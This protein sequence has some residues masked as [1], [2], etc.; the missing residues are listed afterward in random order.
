VIGLNQRQA[1]RHGERATSHLAI[2]PPRWAMLPTEIAIP[3]PVPLREN[4]GCIRLNPQ[5]SCCCRDGGRDFYNSERPTVVHKCTVYTLTQAFVAD[6]ELQ[7]CSR[8]PR[9]SRRYIGPEPRDI[10]LFNYNNRA[11][12]SHEVLNEYISAFSSSVTPFEAWVDHMNRRYQETTP[13]IPF[14]RGALFRSAWFAYGRL[15][16]LDG[17]KSCPRCGD[18]PEN[19]IWDGVSIA[20]SRKHI[21]DELQPP[22]STT[23]ASQIRESKPLSRQEWLPDSAMRRTLRNW[24]EAGGLGVESCDDD[25]HESLKKILEAAVERTKTFSVLECWLRSQHHDLATLFC[26]RLGYKEVGDDNKWRPQKEYMS[27]FQLVS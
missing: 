2:P 16:S 20:F 7:N 4:P 21:N 3:S 23:D 17:D 12:F 11:L 27:L 15:L 1:R 5:G 13:Y 18:A 10:G 8:C 24:L 19:I 6:I 22:T 14:A 26:N 25:D 9:A